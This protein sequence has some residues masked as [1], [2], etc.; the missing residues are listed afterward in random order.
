M[1]SC[2]LLLMLAGVPCYRITRRS[3]SGGDTQLKR[4]LKFCLDYSSAQ[5]IFRTLNFVVP[6]QGLLRTRCAKPGSRHP[7]SSS[8]RS[9]SANTPVVTRLPSNLCGCAGPLATRH[10]VNND[11]RGVSC[12]LIHSPSPPLDIHLSCLWPLSYLSHAD[13]MLSWACL[14]L[15][16][17]A[18]D[19]SFAALSALPS[20][21]SRLMRSLWRRIN[22]AGTCFVIRSAQLYGPGTLTSGTASRTIC[23]CNQSVLTSRCLTLD[24][25]CRSIIPCAAFASMCNIDRISLP[26]MGKK[27]PTAT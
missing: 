1:C 11:L 6:V 3:V 16:S 13:S 21:N 23:S 26:I 24:N 2:A 15:C 22:S 20:L 9:P 25:P 14:R 27:V 19:W 17:F 12:S 10:G 5:H 18:M 7:S 8:S 4:N